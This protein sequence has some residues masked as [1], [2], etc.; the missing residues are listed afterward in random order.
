MINK[1]DTNSKEFLEEKARTQEFVNKVYEVKGFV[2]NPDDEINESILVGLTRNK[3]IYGTRYCPCFMVQGETKEERKKAD[4][5]VCPCKPALTKEIPED[6][7]CHCGI[8]CTPEYAK[9]K[10]S[11]DIVQDENIKIDLSSSSFTT[12]NLGDWKKHDN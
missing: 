12:L 2:K 8:F 5:R 10:V 11:K 4:N 1:I 3:M 7:V 9:N 6:G